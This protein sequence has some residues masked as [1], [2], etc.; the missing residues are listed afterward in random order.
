MN[1]NFTA[2][3]LTVNLIGAQKYLNTFMHNLCFEY[4]LFFP[5]SEIESN[6]LKICYAGGERIKSNRQAAW[7]W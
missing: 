6:L 5:L 4:F 3:P 2:R 7:Q 1:R